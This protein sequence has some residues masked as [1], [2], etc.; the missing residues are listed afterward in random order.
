VLGAAIP[1]IA[2]AAL[3]VAILVAVIALEERAGARRRARG[4][5]SPLD[6]LEAGVE[7]GVPGGGALSSGS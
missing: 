2:V 3:L 1:A 5:P 7:S 6:R 4:E